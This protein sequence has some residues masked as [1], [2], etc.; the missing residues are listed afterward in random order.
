MAGPAVF[1]THGLTLER[2]VVPAT[3]FLVLAYGFLILVSALSVESVFARHEPTLARCA[4][5]GLAAHGLFVVLVCALLLAHLGF[6]GEFGA[7]DGAEA[8]TVQAAARSQ[9]LNINAVRA[10]AFLFLALG[11]AALGVLIAWSGAVARWLGWY[12]A[13]A[14]ALGFA[15]VLA[16]L[17]DVHWANVAF[18]GTVL[19]M[20]GFLLAVGVRLL[21]RETREAATGQGA[22]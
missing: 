9:A 10:S 6:A 4:A 14:G 18:I 19:A 16:A 13:V 5:F 15:V 20:F 22:T 2:G 11:L 8:D 1:L 17:F 21:A 12:G 3:I 7:T